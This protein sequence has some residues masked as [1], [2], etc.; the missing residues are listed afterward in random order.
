VKNDFGRFGEILEKTR[1]RL[2]QASESID[3]AFTRTRS[4][5][6]RLEAVEQDALPEESAA[7]DAEE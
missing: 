6:R 2:Q 7:E 5:Q 1:I 4:I 3:T